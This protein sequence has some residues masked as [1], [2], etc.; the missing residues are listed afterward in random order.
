[1]YAGQ[2]LDVFNLKK[3]GGKCKRE[4]KLVVL[5]DTPEIILD[6]PTP[7]AKTDTLKDDPYRSRN[8]F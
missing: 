6:S 2:C 7:A 1:M 4:N 5:Q 3:F 8:P